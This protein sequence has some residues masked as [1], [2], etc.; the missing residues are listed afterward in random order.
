MHSRSLIAVIVAFML[1]LDGCSLVGSKTE[2]SVK[3]RE[4]LEVPPDLAVPAGDDLSAAAA[5][6]SVTYS[7]YAGKK[8]GVNAIGKAEP[9]VPVS[10]RARLERDGAQRWLVVQG[11]PEAVLAQ[12]RGYFQHNQQKLAVDDPKI[13][14]LET[15]WIERPVDMGDSVFGKLMGKLH[16]TGLRDKFRVRVEPGR[17]SGTAEVYVSHRG[18]E[19]VVTSV[20]PT[21]SYT[22]TTW[23]SRPADPEMEA[24]M[25]AKLLAYFG[26]GEQQAKSQVAAT[27]TGGAS[28]KLVN[29]ALILPPEDMDSAWRRV[30][31]ALDRAGIVVEDRDRTAGIFY[32]RYVD[33]AAYG[34]KGIFSF[35]RENPQAAASAPDAKS[36][37]PS[38]R[39]QVRLKST[40][41]GINVSVFDIKGDPEQ[42]KVSERLLDRLQQQLR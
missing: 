4:A 17:A 33:S 39:F 6:D 3:L 38:D 42:S 23:E 12:T 18:E 35:F 15:D 40:P 36:E 41:T 13:G 37:A 16:S 10:S 25:L 20:D 29:G 24:E 7:G 34:R 27:G 11:S 32:V 5:K 9:A 19:E 22:E 8:P 31:Q 14:V 1:S 30:G 26:V 2:D 28:A 21:T